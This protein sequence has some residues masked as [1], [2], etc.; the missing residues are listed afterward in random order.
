MDFKE[1][2]RGGIARGK[3]VVGGK[4]MI[5]AAFVD[6]HLLEAHIASYP[7]VVIN[8]DIDIKE[9]PKN[10]PIS[11]DKDGMYYISYLSGLDERELE[12]ARSIIESKK[13]EH[14][15][16]DP[17]KLHERQKWEWA[18]TYVDQVIAGNEY[19]CACKKEVRV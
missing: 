8:S 10:A 9:M 1:L 12:E 19:C 13:H 17:I 14:E 4:M 5:G 18:Q 7:R 16:S 3:M 15:K 2:A 6:A 11:H